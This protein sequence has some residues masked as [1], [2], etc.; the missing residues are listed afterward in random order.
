[1]VVT[2]APGWP[3]FGVKVS[4]CSA[5]VTAEAEPVSVQTPLAKVKATPE[6]K[7]FA[8]L[9]PPLEKVIVTVSRTPILVSDRVTFA[10]GVVVASAV[11]V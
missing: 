1:M 7:G 5:F 2:G 11:V 10:N 4:R 6:T 3:L 9:P 8:K